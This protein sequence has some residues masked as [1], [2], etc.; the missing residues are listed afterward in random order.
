MLTAIIL[1][2]PQSADLLSRQCSRDQSVRCLRLSCGTTT[3]KDADLSE[4]GDFFPTYASWNSVLFETSVILTT[5]E[6]ADC[7]FGT[8][9]VAF[10]HSDIVPHFELSD[11]WGR[12]RNWLQEDNKRSIGL[13]APVTFQGLWDDWLVPGDVLFTP[14]RDPMQLHCFDNNIHV[15]DYLKHYDLDIYEWAMDCQPRLIYSHQFACSRQTF[16][17]LGQRLYDVA[18]R[19]KLQDA[20]FWTPHLFERLI[21]LYLARYGGEPVLTTAFWH[22]SSSGAFGPGA[23]NLYGPRAF[24]YYKICSRSNHKLQCKQL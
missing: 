19:L 4:A 7:L 22:H 3:V 8:G 20:G 14:A 13:T 17:Y 18:S 11:I 16:D 12:V 5:W 15:W 6:H 9:D 24:R 23:L 21:A 10:I 1:C 2:H